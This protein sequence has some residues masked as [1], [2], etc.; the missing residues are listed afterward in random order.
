[1]KLSLQHPDGARNEIHLYPSG[2]PHAPLILIS[3]AMGLRASYY[4]T[5]AEN[6]AK[7]GMDACTVDYRGT[8]LS[9]L[10]ASRK[11]DFG[12]ETL[13]ADLREVVQKLKEQFPTKPLFLLGHSLGGQIGGLYTSRYPGELN[14]LILIA[15]CTVYYKGWKEEGMGRVKIAVNLFPLLANIWGYFPGKR[16]GFGG[17]E[18]R[19][20]LRDWGVNGKEG[21]YAPKGSTFDYEAAL[22]KFDQPLLAMSLEGDDFAPKLAVAGLVHKLRA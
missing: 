7:N 8:G 1:M 6:F 13:V 22:K 18:A 11:V 15:A 20:V 21:I 2:K 16:L 5:M 14:G 9:S 19:T 17:R 12:Y 10:R 3:P 4:K